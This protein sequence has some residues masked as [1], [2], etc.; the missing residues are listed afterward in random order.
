MTR[1]DKLLQVVE[2]DILGDQTDYQ[3]LKGLMQSLYGLL[4]RRD[5]PAIDQSNAS[6][7]QHLGR[8]TVRAARRSKVLGAFGLPPGNAA[9][10]PLLQLYPPVRA[11]AL[12]LAW[13]Q[14][15]QLTRECKA[16]NERNGQLLALHHD[17]LSQLL[18]ATQVDPLYQ[19]QHY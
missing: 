11:D 12:R 9:I 2:E 3:Q 5:C 19:P 10:E 15:E 8:L 7:S 18:V 1:R 4:M 6:I 16:L 13:R 14:L 17:L